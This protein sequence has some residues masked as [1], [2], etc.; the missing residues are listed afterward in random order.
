M[1]DKDKAEYW[2][3]HVLSHYYYKDGKV[4]HKER[5]GNVY[6][7]KNYAHKTVGCKDKGYLR[8]RL[9]RDNKRQSA[10]VHRMVW[11]L[12]TGEWPKKTIDHING[13]TLDNRFE[14]LRD[15]TQEV[16]NWNKMPYK[17]SI[18]K[19]VY[20]RSVGNWA[21]NIAVG[22]GKNEGLG[23]YVCLGEALKAYDKRSLELRGDSAFTNLPQF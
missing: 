18:F 17:G 11:L 12:N 1:I 19:G 15:C 13:D 2:K 23:S 6:F 22:G 4:Y 9:G 14:N 8:C 5:L 20:K 10:L 7:N 21:V 3:K 16:N